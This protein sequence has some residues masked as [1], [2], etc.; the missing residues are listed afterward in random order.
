MRSRVAQVLGLAALAAGSLL[1][2][3][4]AEAKCKKMGFLVNDYGKDGPSKDAQ[5]LLDKHIAEWAAQNGITNYKVGKKDVTCELYLNLILFDEHTCTASANVCWDEGG[6]SKPKSS[7]KSATDDTATD[8]GKSKDKSSEAVNPADKPAEAAKKSVAETAPAEKKPDGASKEAAASEASPA[9]PETAAKPETAAAP[10]S[11]T[12]PASET[13]P[14]TT[15]I[16]P[17]APLETGA[18]DAPAAPTAPS[19]DADLAAKAA[20]A[21]ER[22]AAAAERA[23]EAAERAVQ[24]AAE[25][26]TEAAAPATATVPDQVELPAFGAPAA[27]ATVPPVETKSN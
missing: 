14:V 6:D 8:G 11:S 15:A 7:S 18:I 12:S 13:A 24:A 19:A 9:S 22:A 10:A 1:M 23:A 21:A 5:D 27:G 20:A 3:V 26:A 2:A 25:R 4:P 16:A 17:A